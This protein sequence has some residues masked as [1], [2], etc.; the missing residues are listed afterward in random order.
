[1]YVIMKLEY[2]VPI[3]HDFLNGKLEEAVIFL[4]PWFLL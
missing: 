4:V 2:E 1:M 3:Y